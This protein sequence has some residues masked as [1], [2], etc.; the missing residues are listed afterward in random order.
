[1]DLINEDIR[2]EHEI[3]VSYREK[4]KRKKETLISYERAAKILGLTSWK[5]VWAWVG[6]NTCTK[7]G[8]NKI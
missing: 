5:T 7:L 3:V 6:K 2:S 1:M 8:V 4:G